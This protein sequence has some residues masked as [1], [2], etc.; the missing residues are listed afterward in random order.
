MT[1]KVPLTETII[2]I[3]VDQNEDDGTGG[4]QQENLE[5]KDDMSDDYNIGDEVLD[6]QYQFSPMNS[7]KYLQQLRQYIVL[8][9]GMELGN[10]AHMEE[11]ELEEL[12]NTEN[13]KHAHR[14]DREYENRVRVDKG[15]SRMLDEEEVIGPVDDQAAYHPE[16]A[17]DYGEISGQPDEALDADRY[18]Y[19]YVPPEVL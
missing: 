7:K 17:E 10:I 19:R 11:E 1:S 8:G 18:V 6:P 12:I 4:P 14:I 13:P 2:D 15:K 16:D 9:Y 5:T 3:D